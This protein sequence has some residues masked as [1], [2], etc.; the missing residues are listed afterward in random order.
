MQTDPAAAPPAADAVS[1]PI[2]P[3]VLLLEPAA[4]DSPERKLERRYVTGALMLVMVLASMEQTV[5]STAMPTIIG[6]LHGLQHYAM[7]TAVYLLAC[8]VSMPL[9]GRLADALGRKPVILGAIGLF[10][11]SSVLA[12][13]ARTMEQLI[14]YR[15]L[16]GLGAGGIMPVVLTILGDIFTLKQRA[17]VQGF[18]SAVWGTASL[19][20]P[21]LGAQLVLR[22]GWRSIF[23]VNLPFGVMSLLVLMARYHDRE[24][25]HPTDLDLPGVAGMTVA[26]AAMLALVSRLGPGG[27]SWPT[28][29]LLGGVSLVAGLYFIRHER[30]AKHPIMPPALMMRR[31]IGPSLLGSCLLGIAFMSLDTFVPLY[32]QGGGGGGAQAAAGVVTPVMLTWALSSMIAAPLLVRWGFRKT[33]TIGAVLIAVAFVGLVICSIVHT[34][35]LV[36]TAVLAIAG[37]GFGPASMSYLLAAQ[38]AVEWQQRGI[39]TGT[40]QFFRTM[41][42]AVGIGLLGAMFK[43]AMVKLLARPDLTR[44]VANGVDPSTLLDDKVQS[45]LAPE[46]L[47]AI[48]HTIASSLV[49]VFIAMLVFAILGIFVTLLMSRRKVEN[50][51]TTQAMEAAVN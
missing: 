37:F 47:A 7:V 24:K 20:G 10:L 46:T 27:W 32:V 36:L 15:G 18:F 19:A 30:R 29:A 16:Q 4:E 12:A 13:S 11:L 48:R 31:E 25:P 9:Y 51:S 5:T 45:K 6:E 21:W 17:H 28:T 26:C 41:G 35:R 8:T 49:W 1:V 43:G 2:V 22:F 34:P 33:A 39:V 44:L 42:A 50:V 3:S 23:F 14:I 38:G 40:L